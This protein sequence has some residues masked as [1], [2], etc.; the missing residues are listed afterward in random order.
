MY[1]LVLFVV[2][3]YGWFEVT[4]LFLLITW[5]IVLVIAVLFHVL[6]WLRFACRVC[7]LIVVRFAC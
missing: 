7:Y 1:G 4:L 2:H 5:F 6:D 3:D